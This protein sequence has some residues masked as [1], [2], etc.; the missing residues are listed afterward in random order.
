M[1]F[2]IRELRATELVM[3]KLSINE[4]QVAKLIAELKL[5]A[6][7]SELEAS[8]HSFQWTSGLGELANAYFAI[9]AI[10]HQTSPIGERPLQGYVHLETQKKVGWD[11]L[12]ERFLIA[13]LN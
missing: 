9:V 4:S 6:V 10:C 1:T 13:A 12:K 2:I 11:Y 8:T 5:S 3:N 7:P